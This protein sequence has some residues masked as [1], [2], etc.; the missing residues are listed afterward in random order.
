MSAHE[1]KADVPV[2]SVDV[3]VGPK[4]DWAWSDREPVGWCHFSLAARSQ[5]GRLWAFGRAYS[6]GHMRR[7]DFITLFGGTAVV[8]PLAAQ[9]QQPER[10]R[11]IGGLHSLAED[12]PESVV[13]RAA[14][15]QALK[16]LGW[17]TAA[18]F[19]STIAGPEATPS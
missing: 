13:R 10:V 6:R 11:R 2:T 14:F 15:E 3:R 16:G 8:W 19:G 7:R 5:S 18:T 17:I 12:D 9:A 1:G 4:A